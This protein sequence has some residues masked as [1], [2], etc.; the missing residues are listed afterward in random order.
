ME[1][2]KRILYFEKICNKLVEKDIKKIEETLI[3]YIKIRLGT[4]KLENT[5]IDME[6]YD[7]FIKEDFPTPEF[8]EKALIF[9]F[10]NSVNL[11]IPREVFASVS[12]TS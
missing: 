11:W 12:I 9:S 3:E 10:N 4:N 5:S 6:I 8:P 2:E 7:I 1:R